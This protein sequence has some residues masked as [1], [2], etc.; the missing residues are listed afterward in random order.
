MYFQVQRHFRPVQL[1]LVTLLV[2]SLVLILA[3]R[4]SFPLSAFSKRAHTFVWP[5]SERF[6]FCV[7]NIVIIMALSVC[8]PA[9]QNL[10]DPDMGQSL[11]KPVDRTDLRDK[12]NCAFFC[13]E[14]EKGNDAN[15]NHV[16]R[17][18][19]RKQGCFAV[20]RI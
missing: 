1:F 2:K 11:S 12:T 16:S 4:Q 3:S 9:C 15:A 17:R 14:K 5:S 19:C 10:E 18:L 20:H 13:F 7:V 8:R 6:K